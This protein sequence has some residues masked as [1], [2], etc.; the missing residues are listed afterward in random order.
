[1]TLAAVAA[2]VAAAL[3]L[4]DVTRRAD[5]LF[6]DL[7]ASH[8]GYPVDDDVVMI[9]IDDRSLGE[10][11]Q[12]PWPRSVH[13]RLLDRLREAGVRGVAFD[14]IL[15]EPDRGDPVHD[16]RLADAIGRSGRVVLPV[17]PTIR[18]HSGPSVEVL[19][20]PV[21]AATVAGIGHTDVQLE[22]SGAARELYLHAGLGESHW[23]ALALALLQLD[24]A[25]AAGPVP[26]LR[27]PADQT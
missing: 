4:G 22:P 20:H 3:S 16:K 5:D 23:P 19:P 26:G 11:G 8:W 17:I 27:R 18:H 9:A 25:H 24:P 7:H 1:M 21:I 12:W 13:A 15:S 6:Y 2:A 10:V 14:L